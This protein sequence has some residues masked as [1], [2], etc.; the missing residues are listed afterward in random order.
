MQQETRTSYAEF[1]WP[2]PREKRDQVS[3]MRRFDRFYEKRLRQ[4]HMLRDRGA[5]TAT[6]LRVCL[7]LA[8]GGHA[9]VPAW[10]TRRLDLDGGYLSRILHK[11]RRAKIVVMRRSLRDGRCRLF[12]L[13]AAGRQ[14][15]DEI[16]GERRASA[17]TFL[18]TLSHRRR[19]QLLRA[20]ATI[21]DVMSR[22]AYDNFLDWQREWQRHRRRRNKRR[23]RAALPS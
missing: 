8:Q 9:T 20:M 16:E 18:R 11:L 14:L 13:E 15:V 12:E 21:E 7:E 3:R 4:S 2:L 5:L 17:R 1:A 22:N 10:L 23:R 19:I 6:D